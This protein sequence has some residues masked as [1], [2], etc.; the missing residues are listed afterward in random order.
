MATKSDNFYF[1]GFVEQ[2]EFS[3]MIVE[4][5]KHIFN[6]YETI[7]IR[8][9]MDE[10]HLLEHTA[11]LKHHQIMNQLIKEFIPP[12]EREDISLLS[13]RLDDLADYLEDI[14]IMLYTYHVKTISQPMM[15]F[16]EIIDQSVSQVKL[17]TEA[18]TNYRKDTKIHSYIVDINRLEENG[19]ILYHE[20]LFQ[21]FS[22]EE[23]GAAFL[24][25]QKAIFSKFEQILDTAEDIAND[26]ANI[27]MKNS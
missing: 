21:L 16:L 11:D 15:Q 17:L 24:I 3:V 26:V 8:T 12:I 9:L 27:I 23:H 18:F 25:G 4:R 19:D 13:Q 10:V 1:H 14:P 6:N 22:S 5:L 7:N 2:A 20:F